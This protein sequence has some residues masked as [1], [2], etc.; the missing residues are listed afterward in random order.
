MV[1]LGPL[2]PSQYR[3]SIGSGRRED[4]Q[5]RLHDQ[6]GRRPS[7]DLVQPAN[8]KSRNAY[9]FMGH[10]GGLFDS[11]EFTRLFHNTAT[12]ERRPVKSSSPP[13]PSA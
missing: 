4:L 10:H 3:M 5:A 13:S 12:V 9:I 8:Y 1:H 6:D 7:R 11:P 2:A